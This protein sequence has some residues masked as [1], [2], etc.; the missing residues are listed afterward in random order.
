MFKPSLFSHFVAHETN[1]YLTENMFLRAFKSG[2]LDS[3]IAP[4]GIRCLQYGRNNLEM[5]LCYIGAMH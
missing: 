5:Y 3:V 2:F 4:L 1:I